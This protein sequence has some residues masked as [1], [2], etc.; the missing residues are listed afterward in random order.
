[1]QSE[2]ECFGNTYVR[3][4]HRSG[5]STIQSM[6]V[7]QCS[8]AM[9]AGFVY[10]FFDRPYSV[11]SIIVKIFANGGIIDFWNADTLSCFDMKYSK[12]SLSREQVLKI[13]GRVEK[14]V[15]EKLKEVGVTVVSPK[16]DFVLKLQPSDAEYAELMMSPNLDELLP[17]AVDFLKEDVLKLIRSQ[18][19]DSRSAKF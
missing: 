9:K 2:Y 16:R 11:I 8:D 17:V 1:M 12:Y 10:G 14:R 15:I 13:L 6:I 19:S 7:L 18:T 4:H 5:Y 3:I